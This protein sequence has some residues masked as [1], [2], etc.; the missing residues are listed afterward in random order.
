[1]RLV[2]RDYVELD[3]LQRQVL[4][5]EEDAT[6]R[7]P[8]AAAAAARLSRINGDVALDPRV[9]DVHAGNVEGLVADADLVLDGTDNFE[10]RFL[11]NDACVKLAKPW[12]YAGCVGAAGMVFA[13]RPGTTACFR[14]LLPEPPAPRST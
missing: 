12:I 6:R 2:D 4:F 10:T 3:N 13:V 1:L 5:E 11:L 14:C 8:K 9:T 7:L